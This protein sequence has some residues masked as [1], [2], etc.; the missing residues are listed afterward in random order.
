MEYL[1]NSQSSIQKGERPVVEYV[2]REVNLIIPMFPD[3]ELAAARI[4]SGLAQLMSFE[5]DIIDEIKLALVEACLNAFEHSKCQDKKV[6]IKFIM[7]E[8]ELE[9]KISDRGVGFKLDKVKKPNIKDALKGGHKRGWGLEIISN[10][11]DKVEI[12]SS[13]KGTTVT[14]VKK[15][16]SPAPIETTGGKEE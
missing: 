15:K 4:A 1:I 7:K 8:D 3:M 9:L 13:D 10:L 14:M 2:K 6:H 12:E 11:M 5:E 16:K